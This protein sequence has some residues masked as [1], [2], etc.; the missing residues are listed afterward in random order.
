MSTQVYIDLEGGVVLLGCAVVPCVAA[1]AKGEVRV[2]GGRVLRPLAFAERTRLVWLAAASRDAEVQLAESVLALSTVEPTG[3]AAYDDVV[4][5]ALAGAGE[6]AP[7][8]DETL[9]AAARATGLS[10]GRLSAA[11][12]REVDALVRREHGGQWNRILFAEPAVEVDWRQMRAEFCGRL[13]CRLQAASEQPEDAGGVGRDG[14]GRLN[15]LVIS[16]DTPVTAR[17]A[18]HHTEKAITAETPARSDEPV[19]A[20]IAGPT[21]QTMGARAA[22]CRSHA[23]QDASVKAHGAQ[24]AVASEAR[25][26]RGRTLSLRGVELGECETAPAYDN[27]SPDI[28]RV[29]HSR[30]SLV[31]GP[32]RTRERAALPTHQAGGAQSD[33]APAVEPLPVRAEPPHTRSTGLWSS[34]P[35][36]VGELDSPASGAILETPASPTQSSLVLTDIAKAIGEML[37]HEADLRGID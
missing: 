31:V 35:D 9:A 10:A 36:L 37:H 27:R 34:H 7:P 12:A 28:A 8:F 26:Q 23:A 24:A 6:D 22:A 2:D 18:A 14:R 25:T 1:G 32:G 20:A 30:F 13:F 33:L 17:A 29:S 3:Q 19:S 16:T 21:N 4:A 5:L 15:P 11:P